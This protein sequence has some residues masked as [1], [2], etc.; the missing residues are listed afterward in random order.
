MLLCLGEPYVGDVP[1]S[2]GGMTRFEIYGRHALKRGEGTSIR[3]EPR[4]KEQETI[5]STDM[6][7]S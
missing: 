2:T 3:E 6:P 4:E 7:G 1:P 5:L